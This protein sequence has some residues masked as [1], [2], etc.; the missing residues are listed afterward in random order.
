[1]TTTK[2]FTDSLTNA[3][4]MLRDWGWVL[5]AFLLAVLFVVIVMGA[6]NLLCDPG[7][8][9]VNGALGVGS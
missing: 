8:L 3:I 7:G 5:A 6:G 4:P 9:C 2:P 1:M